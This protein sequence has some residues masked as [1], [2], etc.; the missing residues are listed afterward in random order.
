MHRMDGKRSI[1]VG[2]A[3]EIRAG[4]HARFLEEGSSVALVTA[5]L[6][7]ELP[8][9]NIGADGISEYFAQVRGDRQHWLSVIRAA[10][11]ALG[12]VDVLVTHLV[13]PTPISPLDEKTEA[14]MDLAWAGVK[15]ALWSVQGVGS[16][17][18]SQSWGR[19]VMLGSQY[20]QNMNAYNGESNAASHAMRGVMRT[21]ATEWLR[22]GVRCNYVEPCADTS[23]FRAYRDRRPETVD[24]LLSGT[25]LGR[26]GDPK[27]DIGSVVVMLACDEADWL[28]GNVFFADGGQHL[29]APVWVPAIDQGFVPGEI[30]GVDIRLATKGS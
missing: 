14:A 26:R 17:L 3:D 27:D 18:K 16:Q 24:A 2:L 13:M 9:T 19:I 4:I 21:I 29:A 20:G 22:F 23:E 11:D 7:G 30:S 12:G 15:V 5:C 25:A 6:E 28:N 10:T 8:K 1:I